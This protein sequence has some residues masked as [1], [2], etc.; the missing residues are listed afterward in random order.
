MEDEEW[1]TQSRLQCYTSR[2]CKRSTTDR[3]W[4]WKIQQGKDLRIKKDGRR[5][6]VEVASLRRYLGVDHGQNEPR[7]GKARRTRVR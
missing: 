7:E 3:F 2:V 6:L 1:I 4:R 5:V